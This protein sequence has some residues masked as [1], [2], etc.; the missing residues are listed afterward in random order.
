MVNMPCHHCKCKICLTDDVVLVH[1][2]HSGD[3][4]S[5]VAYHKECYKIL[6]EG[7]AYPYQTN[8]NGK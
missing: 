4:G 1:T 3:L 8:K 5:I 7:Y 6:M 2:Y